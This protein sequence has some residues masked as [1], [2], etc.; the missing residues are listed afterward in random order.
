MSQFAQLL[1]Q[2]IAV[3]NIDLTKQSCLH[4]K[5]EL[6]TYDN[7][8]KVSSCLLPYIFRVISH[9]F[10]PRMIG[11]LAYEHPATAIF[12]RVI[13][14]AT[15]LRQIT[16]FLNQND[17]VSEQGMPKGGASGGRPSLSLS[18]GASIDQSAGHKIA[19]S[20]A[21]SAMTAERAAAALHVSTFTILSYFS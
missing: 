11:G 17:L 4:T 19:S 3:S 8:R 20:S 10:Q 13:K 21:S 7:S 5:F 12:S 2:L 6:K 15:A 1:T 16:D 14:R 18:A 9:L